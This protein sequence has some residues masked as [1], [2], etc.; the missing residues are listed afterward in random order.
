M[1]KLIYS[2][3]SLSII[4]V[5]FP[6]VRH[7]LC[8]LHI[9]TRQLKSESICE[10]VCALAGLTKAII[11]MR[12]GDLASCCSENVNRQ[13]TRPHSV[14]IGLGPM[15]LVETECMGLVETECIIQEKYLSDKS[16]ILPIYSCR[17][18]HCTLLNSKVVCSLRRVMCVSDTL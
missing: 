8:F 17:C 11:I 18:T 4:C 1:M 9:F 16:E 7:N 13:F 10:A 15:G 5:Y 3:R 12:V 6:P 14:G 2:T